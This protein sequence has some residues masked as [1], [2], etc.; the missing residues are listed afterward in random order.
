MFYAS[1]MWSEL[2]RRSGRTFLTALGLGVGVGLVVAVS[3]LS[4]GLDDAQQKVLEPLTG[5]GTDM[6]VTRPLTRTQTGGFG[7]QGLSAKERAQLRDEVGPGRLDL[8]SVGDPGQ[9]FSSTAFASGPQLTFPASEV[10]KLAGLGG[11]AD[12][13]GSLTLTA[14]TISGTVPQNGFQQPQQGG[15]PGAGG[16][17]GGLRARQNIDFKSISVTG[18]DAAKPTLA[19]MTPSQIASGRYLAGGS[20]HELV[21]NV[22]YAKQNRIAVGDT[23]TLKGRSFKVVGLAQT[24]LGGTATDMYVELGQLQSLADR[25]GRVNQVQVRAST[26]AGVATAEKAIKASFS[27]ASVTTSADLAA[28]IGGSL[29]D[30]KKLS[31][32][33]GTALTIV[34][35]VAA[36]MIA[37]LLT[38]SSV[39]K[40]VRELG[41]L[42][43]LGW[44]QRLVVRQVAGESVAQGLIGGALGAALGI[45]AAALVN[46]AGI[47]LKATVAAPQAASGGGP[48]FGGPGG[49]PGGFGRPQ[50][51]S[52]TS[53]VVLHAPVDV[54]L[55]LIAVVLA[56]A[57]GLIAGSAGGLRAARL[58]PAA[59]LR[60]IG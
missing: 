47:T 13:A 5:V 14:T 7:G 1:Y 18:V 30:A 60:H 32:K 38:L 26:G 58:R 42:K 9:K 46:A 36:F 55:L 27:G 2:R 23:V 56:V 48:G 35:L 15:P 24:P 51:T 39:T 12:A 21:V 20:A 28:R 53:D 45:G 49:G 6:T 33:L 11:V 50:V 17:G 34:A 22:A 29:T 4:S 31:G 57:G 16:G 37:S 52:G 59:A 54:Q 10:A 8:S 41:T 40:R 3:A 43:A 19:A 25:K 44:P